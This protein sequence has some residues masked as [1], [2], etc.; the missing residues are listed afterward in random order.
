MPRE[1]KLSGLVWRQTFRATKSRVEMMTM[2]PATSPNTAW[3]DRQ[4]IN[5]AAATPSRNIPSPEYR[6]LA[7]H[8]IGAG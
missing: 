2:R 5:R 3:L 1:V 7:A 4:A 6:S 8:M